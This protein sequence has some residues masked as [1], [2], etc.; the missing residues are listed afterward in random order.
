M[1]REAWQKIVDSYNH[2]DP[3]SM[4][5]DRVC[6]HDVS[7]VIRGESLV[8]DQ[9]VQECPDC[10]T[11]KR[12]GRFRMEIVS[13]PCDSEMSRKMLNGVAEGELVSAYGDAD[14]SNRGGL[15]GNVKWQGEGASLVGRIMAV[16][17]A[18][19]H[20]DPVSE[21]E[22]C[23]MPGHAEGWLRA[24][25]VDGDCTGCRVNGA[26]TYKLDLSGETAEFYATLEGLLICQCND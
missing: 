24:A 9:D 1:S 5:Q 16:L 21:C 11:L 19:N 4:Y 10:K 6:L 17:N 23:A 26:M 22:E 14:L 20:H 8:S 18:G 25:I 2:F 7:K 13:G 12:H 15:S 3:T